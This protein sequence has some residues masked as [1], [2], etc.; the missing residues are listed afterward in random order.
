MQDDDIGMLVMRTI[1]FPCLNDK[2]LKVGQADTELQQ[3][4]NVNCEYS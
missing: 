1:G 3:N 2:E 4:V